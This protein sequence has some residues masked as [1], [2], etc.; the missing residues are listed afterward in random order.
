MLVSLLFGLVDA[1]QS[2]ANH[3]GLGCGEVLLGLPLVQAN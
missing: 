3:S 2:T 1:P